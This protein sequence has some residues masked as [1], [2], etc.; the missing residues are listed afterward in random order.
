MRRQKDLIHDNRMW[1]M[2]RSKLGNELDRVV[3][4]GTRHG[5]WAMGLLKNFNVR[6]LL[7]VDIWPRRRRF[8]RDA[9]MWLQNLEE[10]RFKTVFP[11]RGMSSEWARVLP[12]NDFHLTFVDGCHRGHMVLEDLEL[13]WPK[14]RIGG[15]VLCHDAHEVDVREAVPKFFVGRPETP[16]LFNSGPTKVKSYWVIK[17]AD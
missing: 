2:I 9:T 7:C 4:I 14:T 3:E 15:L 6:Q 12:Y 11:L 13:W 8:G 1:D 16:V 17:E 5:H 10:W